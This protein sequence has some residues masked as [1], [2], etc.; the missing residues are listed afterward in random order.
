M[1][2]VR[3]WSTRNSRLLEIVYSAF[4][5]LLRGL[6]PLAR[7]VG[8]GR[9]ERPMAAVERA[10]KGFLFDCRM[11][12]QCALSVNGMACPTNCPKRLR[13]GPCGGVRA[14]GHCE[15][16]PEMR[17]VFLEG[18][19]GAQR[20]A[21]GPSPHANPPLDHRLEGTSS[22]LRV[23][24]GEAKPQVPAP[25][26][27]APALPVVSRLQELL[28]SGAFTVTAEIAPPDSSDPEEVYRRLEVFN[29]CVDALNVTDASG[30]NCHMS[31]LAMSVLLLQA[32]CEPIMQMTCRD[33]NRIAIQ[34]DILG[35]A[36]LGVRNLL[37][38]SGDAVSNGD[39]PGAR[40]V[41]DLDSIS[42]LGTVRRMRDDGR[43]LSGRPIEAPPRLFLGAADNPFAPPFDGRLARLAKKT[44]AGA[45]FIQTQ[46]CFDLEAM[47]RYMERV[48]A[49]GLDSRCQILVGVGPIGSAKT[50]R[51]L[52][53][54]V[55]GVSIPDSVVA[56]LEKA[57]DPRAEGRR[58]C[59]ELIRG[60][61]QIP[62]I[63]G[64]HLMA[65]KQE[66]AV[67]EIVAE[68][69]ALGDRAPLFRPSSQAPR[70]LE[71]SMRGRS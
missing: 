33:R 47:R 25:M 6:G 23:V 28:A 22:W 40:H 27:A 54:H 50:A 52:R 56:R 70:A 62:G 5:P 55:P 51:W 67:A 1:R 20:M 37:C 4:E 8:A 65:P 13:N 45:Q 42:L 7:A 29:G 57:S 26:P 18:W 35:A 64:V 10:V 12:G 30:A 41:G 53:A 31:S 63:A 11:C 66:R 71:A 17:C 68:S 2:A 43:F 14:D 59:I 60:L 19:N 46:Y 34:G 3:Y 36:A 69:G 24:T 48:R 49:E 15:A 9:L 61:R 21:R 39:H 44:R 32:G 58:I 38:L 16:K